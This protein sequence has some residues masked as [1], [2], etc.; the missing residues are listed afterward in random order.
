METSER[1][2]IH[3]IKAAKTL[4]EYLSQKKLLEEIRYQTSTLGEKIIKLRRELNDLEAQHLFFCKQKWELQ[5]LIDG[6]KLCDTPTP[7]I[8]LKQKA[9]P[10]KKSLF[11]LLSPEM[12]ELVRA[13]GIS[14][15]QFNKEN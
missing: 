10:K 9:Q 12:Q 3:K 6:F 14:E 15:E 13:Q 8:T 2:K 4:D 7:G 11:A 5:E 1:P